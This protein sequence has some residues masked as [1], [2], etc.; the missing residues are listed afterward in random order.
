M[1]AK[2]ELIPVQISPF[3]PYPV[4]HS[5]KY[6]PAVFVQFACKS[7]GALV[8]SLTSVKERNNV[9]Q[10]YFFSITRVRAQN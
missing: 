10:N 7:H 3:P 9:T 4:K 8:H 1:F 5:Q 6:E 2:W